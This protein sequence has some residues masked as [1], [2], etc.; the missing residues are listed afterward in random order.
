MPAL[1]DMVEMLLRS[2]LL[3]DVDPAIRTDLA[4]RFE[5]RPFTAGQTLIADGAG[6]RALLEILTGTAE[7]FVRE[8]DH[9][10]RVATLEPGSLVGEGAFFS[11]LPRAAD[12]VG[13]SEGIVA[14]LPWNAYL[15]LAQSGHPG[16]EAI[17]RAVV[18]HLT[19][20][21]KETNVRLSVLLDAQ[22]SGGLKNALSKFFGIPT[23][24]PVINH[25]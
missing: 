7:V 1:P 4:L 16:A 13:S 15:N 20:R 14:V 9:R 8:G 22:R 2:P 21:V 23:T 11:G 3:A 17:E 25:D 6:G 18:T 12:I 24:A 5:T 10:Y 19:R